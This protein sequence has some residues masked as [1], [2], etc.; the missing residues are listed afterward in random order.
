MPA[1]LHACVLPQD[2]REG[3]GVVGRCQVKRH[4]P[5]TAGHALQAAGATLPALLPTGRTGPTYGFQDMGLLRLSARL[6]AAFLAGL[7]D[8]T[9]S[10]GLGGGACILEGAAVCVWSGVGWGP[11]EVA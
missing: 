10:L 4:A 5:A 9:T 11:G 1:P 7:A 2:G 6:K 3:A 8:P